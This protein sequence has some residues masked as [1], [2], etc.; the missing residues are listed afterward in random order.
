[1]PIE[2]VAVQPLK[3]LYPHVD[4]ITDF[5]TQQSVKLLWDRIFALQEQLAAAQSTI[6]TL[7]EGHNANESAVQL[8]ARHAREAIAIAQSSTP[9][10]ARAADVPGGGS[11][12]ELPG[13]GDGGGGQTGFNAGLP[14]GHGGGGGLSAVHAGQIVGGTMNEFVAL[15]NPTPD[16]ATRLTNADELVRRIIWH[17]QQAGFTAGRQKNPSG[18][19]SKD[20][21]TVEVDG[22]LRAYDIFI[23]LSGFTKQLKGHMGEVGPAKMATDSGIPD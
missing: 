18:L 1:M 22:V 12:E 2:P 7:V 23:D 15:R 10:E 16:E 17:L 4:T 5:S 19:I 3:H 6:T 21:I 8:A 11:G 9:S 14:N 20:K 13:G